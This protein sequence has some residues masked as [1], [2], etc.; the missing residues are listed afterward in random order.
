MN[1]SQLQLVLE[2]NQEYAKNLWLSTCFNLLC[3]VIGLLGNGYVLFV[4]KFKLQDKTGS[5]YFIPY[6]AIADAFTSSV[7]CLTFT[8]ENFHFLYFPWDILCKGMNFIS[9]VVAFMAGLFLLAIAIQRYT[10]M[11]PAGRQFS[12][13]W[14]RIA[15]VAILIVSVTFGIPGFIIAGV[16]EIS[17]EY[18]GVNL[19]SINCQTRNNYYPIFQK[20]YYAFLTAGVVGNFAA[21]AAL[22]LSIAVIARRRHGKSKM[23]ARSET[24]SDETLRDTEMDSFESRAGNVKATDKCSLAT[25][26]VPNDANATKRNEGKTPSTR[27]SVMFMTIVAA[28]VMTL[29]PPGGIM[30]M[31]VVTADPSFWLNLP[32]W[33][34]QVYIILSR[35][36]VINN[37]VNPFVYGYFDL[38][39]RKY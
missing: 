35:F 22:Y 17:L 4:Y 30:V 20:V 3:L 37:I 8:F 18:K 23:P 36:W 11:H 38:E 1:E 14:R 25:L 12:L 39:F 7:L 21:I 5:R 6:L 31:L 32:V 34:L 2:Y 9:S 28:Y 24:E 10:K 13:F 27:F 26:V 33:R 16:G 19:T 29:I 15:V